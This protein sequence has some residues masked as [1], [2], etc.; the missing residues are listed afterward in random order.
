V[1][2]N[3]STVAVDGEPLRARRTSSIIAGASAFQPSRQRCDGPTAQCGRALLV[4]FQDLG[5]IADDAE[6]VVHH[7]QVALQGSLY[8]MSEIFVRRKLQSQDVTESCQAN[9]IREFA[10]AALAGVVPTLG[11][12]QSLLARDR[13]AFLSN[14]YLRL[15]NAWLPDEP[16]MGSLPCTQ[17]CII[18]RRKP[19]VRLS[20]CLFKSLPQLPGSAYR[21][22]PARSGSHRSCRKALT[23]PCDP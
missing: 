7:A 14:Q 3:A 1:C 21:N 15:E 20:V 22:S 19:D 17:M 8:P 12:I 23:P 5:E 13:V 4:Q 10:V 16:G 9:E 2:D 6:F 18:D 11:S